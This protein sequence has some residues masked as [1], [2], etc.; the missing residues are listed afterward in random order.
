MTG[1]Q[2][3]IAR[4]NK[5]R[6]IRGLARELEIPEQSI[7]RLEAGL[8]IRLDRAKKLA[9]FFEVQVTDLAPFNGEL[10]EAA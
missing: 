6:S 8:G 1:D 2:I 4:M 7:R 3:R 5:G 9:D 10:G